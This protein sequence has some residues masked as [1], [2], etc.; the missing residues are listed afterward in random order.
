MT[1]EEMCGYLL[2]Y[3][4]DWN[5]WQLGGLSDDR[6]AFPPDG[7]PMICDLSDDG[8]IPTDVNET[9][10]QLLEDGHIDQMYVPDNIK[11]NW[12]AEIGFEF[13][14]PHR[15]VD[16]EDG[17]ALVAE[18]SLIAEEY[19]AALRDFLTAVR[20][21][22]HDAAADYQLVTT[23]TPLEPLLREFLTARLPKSKH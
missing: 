15:F 3:R 9:V 2:Q 18:P 6:P 23:D 5:I 12:M 11:L 20:A 19:K 1:D 22:C 13:D 17:T 4:E 7:T 8:F 10:F 14:R 21:K 16:L